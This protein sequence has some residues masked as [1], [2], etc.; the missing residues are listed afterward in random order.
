PAI[1]QLPAQPVLFPPAA[2]TI[3]YRKPLVRDD[4]LLDSGTGGVFIDYYLPETAAAP[5][6]LDILDAAGQVIQSFASD[7]TIN[8]PE[9][10]E[11]MALNQQF[12]LVDKALEAQAG[13][14]RFEWDMTLRGPWDA[15]A[16]RRYKNGPLAAPGNYTVRLS[17]GDQVQEQ[18]FSL[19]ADPRLSQSG[20]TDADIRAQ[21]ALDQ[22]VVT[23][24]S[25]IRQTVA[26]W[27]KELRN[28][29][30]RDRL[31]RSEAARRSALEK[32]LPEVQTEEAISYPQ[33]MLIDQ[34][35]YLHNLLTGADQDPG[36]DA[37]DR[38]TE[39]AASWAKIK[40]S[41]K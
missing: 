35:A 10:V 4:S 15:R 22:Q 31:S 2:T 28:L 27:N 17:V 33:P 25:E 3:R 5:L 37:R 16:N 14:H 36:R 1:A 41:I 24:L 20:V 7:S 18:A 34:V 26:A 23:L 38:Y 19:V 13:G 21:V 8:Q 40:E 30:A 39:L 11:N 6:R 12:Y 9:L 32:V 29:N